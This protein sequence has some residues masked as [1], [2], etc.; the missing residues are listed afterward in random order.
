MSGEEWLPRLV[1]NDVAGLDRCSTPE[2]Q[3]IGGENG[4]RLDGAGWLRRLVL[5]GSC[6]GD[7]QGD[8]ERAQK[9][10][11]PP[12]YRL[13]NRPQRLPRRLAARVWFM[14]PLHARLRRTRAIYPE[15][16]PSHSPRSHSAVRGVSPRLGYR[17]RKQRGLQPLLSAVRLGNRAERV[18]ERLEDLFCTLVIGDLYKDDHEF[19]AGARLK[20]H[21]PLLTP[22]ALVAVVGSPESS[23]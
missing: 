1:D 23:I 3:H 14:A 17:G 13:S 19:I 6:G 10:C 21:E 16:A 4:V 12:N 9:E 5:A 7:P 11:Q 22:K 18:N 15:R 8:H 2:P 20:D